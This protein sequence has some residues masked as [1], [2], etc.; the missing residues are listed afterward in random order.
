MKEQIQRKEVEE[1]MAKSIVPLTS[2]KPSQGSRSDQR[3]IR[4]K[5]YKKPF[6]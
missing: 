6:H 2:G 1:N 5:H 4:E 3:S